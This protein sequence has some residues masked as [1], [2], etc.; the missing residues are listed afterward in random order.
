M[1]LLSLIAGWV[2]MDGYGMSPW[3]LG[4]LVVLSFAI[5]VVTDLFG[6]VFRKW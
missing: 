4:V 3:T 5:D 2:A 1:T 6:V